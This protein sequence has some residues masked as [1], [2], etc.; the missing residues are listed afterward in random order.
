MSNDHVESIAVVTGPH[1]RDRAWLSSDPD[2]SA[3]FAALEQAANVATLVQ[4]HPH[5]RD[6]TEYRTA[7][8]E[9]GLRALRAAA[10]EPAEIGALVGCALGAEVASPDPLYRAHAGIGLDPSA[11]VMITRGELTNLL[12]AI[13]IATATGPAYDTRPRLVLV[14]SRMSQWS[15]RFQHPLALLV[16]DAVTAMVVGPRRG[17]RLLGMETAVLGAEG[18]ALRLGTYVDARSGAIGEEIVVEPAAGA[19]LADIGPTLPVAI[20]RRLL[21]RFGLAPG[22]VALAPTQSIVGLAERWRQQLGIPEMFESMATLGNAGPTSVGANLRAAWEQA[23]ADHIVAIQLGW[24]LH[25]TAALFERDAP[26]PT[27]GSAT[28]APR[29]G[30]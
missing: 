25:F 27:D 29:R 6:E 11:P 20:T 23:R 17:L 7:L 13:A 1:S 30:E 16:G 19:I 22:N 14:G 28:L 18:G 12:D 5:F 3:L 15:R 24:G 4:P 26:P 2:A 9:A 21:D 8:V 10:R